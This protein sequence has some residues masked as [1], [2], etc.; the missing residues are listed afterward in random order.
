LGDAA[1]VAWDTSCVDWA[2]RI[3]AGRSLLPLL[4]LVE[5]EATRAVAIFNMLRLPDV[6]GQPVMADAAGEWQRDLVRAIFGS[7]DPEAGKRHVREVFQLVPKKNS[8]TTAGAA[9]MLTA[10]LMSRRPRAEFLLVAPTQEVANLAFGQAVG[11]VEAEPVLRAKFHIQDHIKRITYRPTGASLKVKSFDPKIVTGAKPS[12][13]LIDELHV[14]AESHDADRVVGQLRGGL[15]SQPEG[16]LLTITTQSERPPAGVFKAELMKARAVR[17]SKLIA[18]ILPLLY[19][20]PPGHDWRDQS[21]WG[22]V[23][24]NN[25]RSI[26][27]ER[28]IEDFGQAEAAGEDELRRWASQHL[29]VEI[30]LALQSDRWAGADFWVQQGDPALTLDALL[31]RSDAVTVG[32]DGGGLDDLLGLAVVGRD[33]DT[34]DWLVWARAWAHPSVLQRRKEVAPRLRDFADEG[35]LSLVDS[36]GDDVQEVADI[37]SRVWASG[38]LAEK[39][40]IGVDAHGIGAILD[41]L[42]QAG[43]PDGATIAISQGWRLTG[44]IKTTERRLAEGG[45]WHGGAGLMAWCVGNARVEPRGNAVMISKQAA[46]SAKI[47]PLMALFNAVALMALNPAAAGRSWWDKEPADAIS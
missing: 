10:V 20:F 23:T 45:L 30:G 22:W 47:D 40:S 29:N 38:L 37:V 24:P 31:E 32:I 25:G 42:L 14:I 16:F 6:P 28:L 12:G 11:M 4:P 17:D 5:S 27:V 26:T 15:I 18:P 21:S 35:E 8:K 33:A 36:V 3:R 46:G 13:V 41:A 1:A 9:I 43:I 44:A 39:Q 34:G 7:Y 2:D 19:E